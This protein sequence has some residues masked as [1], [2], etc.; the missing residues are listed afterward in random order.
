VHGFVV[1]GI[2]NI[3]IFIRRGGVG[4]GCARLPVL[5]TEMLSGAGI[6]SGVWGLWG[7]IRSC[8]VGYFRAY[9]QGFRMPTETELYLPVCAD[10][11]R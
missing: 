7:G 1:A 3:F 11:V 2:F 6:D 5:T 8:I 9:P 10:G 4:M